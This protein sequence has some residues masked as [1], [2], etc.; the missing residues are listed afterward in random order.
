[1]GVKE[2]EL[3]NVQ[4]RVK[5]QKAERDHWPTE[6]VAKPKMWRL[7]QACIKAV[8]KE[9]DEVEHGQKDTNMRREGLHTQ[10]VVRWR[11]ERGDGMPA[12]RGRKPIVNIELR[13]E[14][15]RQEREILRQRRRPEQSEVVIDV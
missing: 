13:K 2:L 11:E 15:S 7:T 6:V 9:H 1:V 3:L 10:Q 8:L 12:K 4:E 14:L 5:G